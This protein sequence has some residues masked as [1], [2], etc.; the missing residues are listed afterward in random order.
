VIVDRVLST[1]FIAA[2][3]RPQQHIVAARLRNLIAS[4]PALG[5][6][7]EVTVPYETVAFSCEKE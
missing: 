6:R 5:G 2:L 3:E 7:D 1:S 4:S